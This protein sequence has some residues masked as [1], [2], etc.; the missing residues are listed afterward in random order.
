MSVL[1]WSRFSHVDKTTVR[2]ESA[3]D[4]TDSP[5]NLPRDVELERDPELGFGF[6]AGS[7]KPV[8]VRSVTEGQNLNILYL[9]PV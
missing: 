6:I 9:L 2:D 5:F 3:D 1:L 8:I 7:E 4:D